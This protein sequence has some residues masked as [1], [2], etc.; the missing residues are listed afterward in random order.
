[1]NR[2]SRGQATVEAALLLPFIALVLLAVV[3][4]GL[5]VRSRIL[6]THAAREGV[7]AAAVGASYKDV[8]AAVEIAGNLPIQRLSVEVSRSDGTATVVVT[9]ADPTDVPL[10]GQLVG[11]A[12]I[13]A[14]ARMRI[15]PG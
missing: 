3:Q 6:I 4:V 2:S 12:N 10:V 7:R 13:V 14:V 5:V 1:V 8:K 9:Y 11:D 15:E